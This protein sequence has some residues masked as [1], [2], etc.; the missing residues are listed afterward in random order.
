MF[1]EHLWPIENRK[2]KGQVIFFVIVALIVALRVAVSNTEGINV[3]I[4]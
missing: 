4:I 3:L 2:N 1:W